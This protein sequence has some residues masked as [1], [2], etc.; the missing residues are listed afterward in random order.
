MLNRFEPRRLFISEGITDALDHSSPESL[1]GGKLGV[2]ATGAA[3]I[4]APELLGLDELQERLSALIP[5]VREVNQ[6]MRHTSNPVTVVGIEKGRA[7]GEYKAQ[8]DALSANLR[9]VFVVDD[10][11]ND[12]SNPYMLI[13]RIVNN[14]EAQ[15]DIYLQGSMVVVDGTNK[16]AVD[17][18]ERRWPDDVMCTPEVISRL[19]EKGV[20]DLSDSLAEQYQI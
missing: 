8:F 10:A 6:F 4:E 12:L 5:E 7:F 3:K 2:D 14:M 17:G 13:W 15:R 19:K 20:W 9:I 11:C 16:S 1:V 18:F